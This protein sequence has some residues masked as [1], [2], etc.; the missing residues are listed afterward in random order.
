MIPCLVSLFKKTLLRAPI[1]V[2]C[3]SG[4]FDRV[5]Y[6]FLLLD[7]LHFFLG[8]DVWFVVISPDNSIVV[9]SRVGSISVWRLSNGQRVFSLA[10]DQMFA[11]PVCIVEKENP[12]LLATIIASTIRLYD[13][14]TGHLLREIQ[15][16][17]L[18][19]CSPMMSTL[20]LCPLEDQ[21]VLYPGRDNVSR[22]SEKG[23][24]RA[25]HLD[26]GEVVEMTLVNSNQTV[27]FIGVT[28]T[29]MVFLA[30]SEGAANSRKGSAVKTTFFTLEL[31][32]ISNKVLARTLADIS[33]KVR[34]YA[35]STNKSKALALG[36]TRF[37]PSA[38]VFRAEIK[39]F[40]LMSSEVIER[41]LTYPSSINLMQFIGSNHIIT[42]S[43]DKI[44]RLWDL[45]RNIPSSSEEHDEDVEVEIVD[46]YG[47]K[48]ICWEKTSVCLVDLRA[49]EY[50]RFIKGLLPQMVFVNDNEVILVTDGKMHLF[51]L[52]RRQRIRQ[53]DGN[54]WTSGLTNGCFVCMKHHVVAVPS[55]QCG[56]C[57][58]DINTGRRTSHMQCKDIRRSVQMIKWL[59]HYKSLKCLR[60][61]SDFVEN[62]PKKYFSTNFSLRVRAQFELP[63]RSYTTQNNENNVVHQ[64]WCNK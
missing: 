41:T 18:K 19:T 31:W 30:L 43:R 63:M 10:Q 51:D 24:I 56:L 61:S 29:G 40:D 15:D 52:T 21:S 48:A 26:S 3:L 55:D 36:N 57:V 4:H 34:C 7:P 53:F 45:D 2:I 39:V 33:D 6:F 27:N 60:N 46:M 42:A 20:C 16:R 1:I 59:L 54:V 35:L 58:Y 23:W 50:I 62:I 8:E 5:Y 47:Y 64:I 44:V 49:G 22:S 12:N 9:T 28:I 32:D 17:K 25:A 38:N 14:Q 13:L 37:L 11:S